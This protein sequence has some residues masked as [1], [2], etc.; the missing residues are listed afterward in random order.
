MLPGLSLDGAIACRLTRPVKFIVL[1]D[2]SGQSFAAFK[3]N[4][5]EESI[6]PLSQRSLLSSLAYHWGQKYYLLNF[7]SSFFW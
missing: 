1:Q 6:D 3:P 5:T 7:Y 4:E 2:S